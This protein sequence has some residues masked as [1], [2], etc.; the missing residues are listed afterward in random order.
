[1]NRTT[2]RSRFEG[3]PP[4]TSAGFRCPLEPMNR[5]PMR[6]GLRQ[7]LGGLTSIGATALL[8]GLL[9]RAMGNAGIQADLLLLGFAT[10][11]GVLERVFLLGVGAACVWAV[12][13]NRPSTLVPVQL[14]ALATGLF[15]THYQLGHALTDDVDPR[16]VS[17]LLA[18][19]ATLYSCYLCVLAHLAI[20][21]RRWRRSS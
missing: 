19:V 6:A 7:H 5:H 10:N 14:S 18:G 11:L 15:L 21:I 13:K 2:A 20:S 9:H 16:F 17:A 8:L 3:A 4:G 1:M 12:A